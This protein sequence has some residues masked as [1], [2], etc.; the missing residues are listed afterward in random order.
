MKVTTMLGRKNYT[1]EEIDQGKAALNQQLSAYKNLVTFVASQTSDKK[2]D[3]AFE[4]FE[5]L[6]FNNMTLILDRYFVHRLPG[7]DYEGKETSL[8]MLTLVKKQAPVPPPCYQRAQAQLRPALYLDALTLVRT[9]HLLAVCH[10]AFR[11]GHHRCPPPLPA[12]P[13]VAPRIWQRWTDPHSQ[14][15]PTV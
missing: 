1:Q 9:L 2:I 5:A 8:M 3:S 14:Q 11:V 4:S 7:A 15:I 13:G 6:F 12:G 10:F